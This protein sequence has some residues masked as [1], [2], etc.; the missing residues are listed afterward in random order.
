MKVVTLAGHCTIKNKSVGFQFIS[1][2]GVYKLGGSFTISG[3]VPKKDEG[4]ESNGRFVYGDSYAGCRLCGNKYVYQC[5]LCGSFNCYDGTAKKNAVCPVCRKPSDIP[6]TISKNIVCST[7][8]P[9]KKNI[10]IAVSSP[11]YDDIGAIL[12]SLNIRYKSFED[13]GFNCDILFLNCGTEDEVE[14]SKLEQ[15][16]SNGGCLYASDLTFD[17]I[18]RYSFNKQFVQHSHGDACKI[19]ATVDDPELRSIVGNRI[20]IEFDLSAWVVLKSSSG[21][22]L[23]SAANGNKYS[24]LPLMVRVPYGKGV[25]FYTSFHNYAQASEKEKALLQLLILKQIGSNSD[26]SIEEVSNNMGVNINSIKAKFSG[27]Q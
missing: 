27:G 1:E 26:M 16:V 20:E 12:D 13:A 11:C 14:P 9:K 3:S 17:H 10:R 22:T 18:L 19:W 21:T 4:E 25:I 6:A 8:P 5:C 2:P 23:L 7:E 24:G 15:F